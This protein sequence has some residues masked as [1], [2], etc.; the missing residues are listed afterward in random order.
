MLGNFDHVAINVKKKNWDKT[1]KTLCNTLGCVHRCTHVCQLE[2]GEELRIA[3]LAMGIGIND[4]HIELMQ[5]PDDGEEG[6]AE[7]TLRVPDLETVYDELKKKGV[8]LCDLT[9][10]KSLPE[11]KKW[12]DAGVHA[13]FAYLPRK[14]FG[15][16]NVELIEWEAPM[17]KVFKAKGGKVT[18][19]P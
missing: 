5:V 1:I 3:W 2:N 19:K 12:M 14:M 16:F 10:E 18:Y 13:K 6:L 15:S 9:A 8:T 7:F 17:E 11:G 4:W